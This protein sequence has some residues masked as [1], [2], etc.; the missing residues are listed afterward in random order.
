MNKYGEDLLEWTNGALL[1]TRDDFPMPDD[2]VPDSLHELECGK[3]G[4]REFRVGTGAS[5]SL[6]TTAVRCVK[7]GIPCIIHQG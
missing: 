2:F 1:E 4:G 6:Y 7:C 3:C 5:A